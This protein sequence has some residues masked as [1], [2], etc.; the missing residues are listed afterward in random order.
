IPKPF[1]RA[2]VFIA[3]PIY[4]AK[5]ADDEEVENKRQELQ[6]KLDQTTALGKQWRESEK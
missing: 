1:T 3:E 2:K 4:V 5:N 6:K